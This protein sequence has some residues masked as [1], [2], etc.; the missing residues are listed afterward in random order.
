MTPALECFLVRCCI[1]SC[2]HHLLYKREIS[3]LQHRVL[4]SDTLPERLMELFSSGRQF[5][6]SGKNTISKLSTVLPLLASFPTSVGVVFHPYYL[7]VPFSYNRFKKGTS[8][9]GT[10]FG[11]PLFCG[12]LRNRHQVHLVDRPCALGPERGRTHP[13][14]P[15]TWK[16]FLVKITCFHK[17]TNLNPFCISYFSESYFPGK[18]GVRQTYVSLKSLR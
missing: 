13:A 8:G 15:L 11:K 2:G 6:Q 5:S 7:Q 3:A 1:S 12:F 16:Q 14:V 17:L 4:V 18:V 10:F 9:R